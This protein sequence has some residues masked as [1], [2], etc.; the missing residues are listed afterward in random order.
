MRKIY[1]TGISGTGKTTVSKELFCRGIRAISI[2]DIPGLCVW[3][4][5]ISNTVVDYD[6][7]LNEKFIDS[8]DWICDIEKLQALI[9]KSDTD[10]VVLGLASNQREF[11]EM[12]DLILLL[13]CPPKLFIER[14]MQRNDN[15]FGKDESAQKVIL[16]WYEDFER[17]MLDQ[18]AVSIDVSKSLPEVTDEIEKY[19][20]KF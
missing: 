15:D 10:V 3:R 7:D 5:K 13:Q 2:D 20:N 6:A 12:F 1:V 18:G 4:N 8:H 19:L 11:V 14:I 16:S 9:D 17:N